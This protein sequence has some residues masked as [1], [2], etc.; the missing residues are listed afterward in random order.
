MRPLKWQLL[1][2]AGGVL[3][4]L[5]IMLGMVWPDDPESDLIGPHD[6]WLH[7]IAFGGLT[8]WYCGIVE[9]RFYWLVALLVVAFAA[10]TEWMQAALVPSRE[11][12]WLDFGADMLGMAAAFLLS[13]LGVDRW[14]AM[15]ERLF[16]VH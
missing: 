1:W 2:L 14:A 16:R 13:W 12:D 5:T 6:K 8:G 7:F 9:R 15:T 4:I 10:G 11:G 3:I